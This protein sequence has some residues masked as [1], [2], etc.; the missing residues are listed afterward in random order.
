VDRAN[1]SGNIGCLDDVVDGRTI[2]GWAKEAGQLRPAQISLFYAGELK[3]TFL[4][5]KYRIDLEQAGIGHGYHGFEVPLPCAFDSYEPELLDLRF[6]DGTPVPRTAQFVARRALP[7]DFDLLSSPLTRTFHLE[8]TSR[9]NLRCVYCPVSQPTY[10]GQD[11]EIADF[12]ELIAMLKARRVQ[13][14]VVNGH[15]ET[16]FVSGWQQWILAL[17]TAGF[18][19][20]IITNFARLLSPEERYAMAHI[21]NIQ[22]SVDTHRPEVLRK[23]RRRVE[24]GDILI[25]MTGVRAAAAAHDLPIPDFGWSCVVTD[26]VAEDLVDYVRFGLSCGVRSFYFCNLTKYDDIAGADNVRHVSTMP[27]DALARFI[28]SLEQAR[29]LVLAAGGEFDVQSGLVDSVQEQLA[30]W[31]RQ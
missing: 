30:M 26:R 15:G 31:K 4:A 12:D 27:A 8:F 21:S 11:I 25:N 7:L 24:L 9:C 28:A 13:Q 10:Q 29:A 2:C 19:L 16:T 18:R 17:A 22:V 6:L 23:V 14:V 1:E 5:G 3:N 20:A